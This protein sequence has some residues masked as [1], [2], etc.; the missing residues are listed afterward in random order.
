MEGESG[1][2]ETPTLYEMWL[3]TQVSVS[4]QTRFFLLFHYYCYYDYHCDYLFF[5][6]IFLPR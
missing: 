1:G 6:F 5:I 3:L 4:Q 2:A